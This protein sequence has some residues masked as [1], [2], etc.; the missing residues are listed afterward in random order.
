M[1][2]IYKLFYIYITYVWVDNFNMDLVEMGWGGVDQ[3]VLAHYMDK[4]RALVS[5]VMDF[6]FS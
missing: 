3:I 2:L 5:V 1:Y 6:R 4:R